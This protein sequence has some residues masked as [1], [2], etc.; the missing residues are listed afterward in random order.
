MTK[1]TPSSASAI[2][3]QMNADQHSTAE[4][5]AELGISVQD[6]QTASKA[7]GYG[8]FGS[9]KSQIDSLAQQAGMDEAA[10]LRSYADTA[11][12]LGISPQNLLFDV[13]SGKANIPGTDQ[14]LTWNYIDDMQELAGRLG[15]ILPADAAVFSSDVALVSQIANFLQSTLNISIDEYLNSLLGSGEGL[16]G[17]IIDSSSTDLAVKQQYFSNLNT[18]INVSP[19]VDFTLVKEIVDS[20]GGT[21]GPQV[22]ADAVSLN[23]LLP[24]LNAQYGVTLSL[25]EILSQ[26]ASPAG[27]LA[28]MSPADILAGLVSGDTTVRG[29]F[30]VTA[31]PPP[32]PAPI[33][34]DPYSIESP[35]FIS[36]NPTA[37]PNLAFYPLHNVDTI[38]FYIKDS[39]VTQSDFQA[40]L[41]NITYTDNGTT[42]NLSPTISVQGNGDLT[43]GF[44]TLVPLGH[45]VVLTIAG[46]PYSIQFPNDPDYVSE[47]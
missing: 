6:L 10:Y 11:T 33:V 21:N 9:I 45:T 20:A 38:S 27:S 24:T 36:P 15:Y 47:F 4:V 7:Y 8:G 42:V 17:T 28:G 44:G 43:W 22:L 19:S 39:G 12:S 30:F 34:I 18:L 35:H 41:N 26:V 13:L 16:T 14:R 40:I 2:N 31:P 23:N 3:A 1:I 46:Q 32:P 29:A 37:Y 25:N 5:A